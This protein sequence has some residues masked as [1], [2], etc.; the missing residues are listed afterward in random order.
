MKGFLREYWRLLKF[1]KSQRFLLFLAI[2]C[3][4]FSTIFE[5]ISLGLIIPVSD[6]V[7]TNQEIAIPGQLPDFLASIVARLNAIEPLTFLRIIIIFIP[8]LF[9]VKGIFLFL[10]DY[11]MNVVGQKVIF[12]VRNSLFNKFQE[13]SMDFYSRIRMG[14][15]M[16]RVTSDVT[17]IT[18]AISYALKDFLFE[19]MKAFVF[20]LLAF[21]IG[22]KISW[23]LPLVAFVIFPLIMFPVI[24]LG[25]RIK[26]FTT[27]MQEKMADLNALMADAIGGA[28]I[29]KAFSRQSHEMKRFENINHGYYRFNI[30]AVKRVVALS[31]LTEFIGTIGVVFIL[32]VVGR[33]VI[34]GRV[35]FGVFGA[36]IAYLMSTIKPLKKLSGVHATNQKALAASSRIYEIL[37]EVPQIEEKKEAED[38]KGVDSCV[39]FKGVWF[40]YSREDEYVLK[41]INLQ[42]KKGEVVALVG[43]SGAG[44][45]TLVNLIPRFYDAEKGNIT[46]DG[47]DV[48][49]LKIEPLRN[50]VSIVSQQTILFH[51]TIRDNIAYGKEGASEEEIVEA[52]KK[53]HAYEFIQDFP[54]KFDSIVGDRGIKLSGGQMQRISIARAILKNAPILVLDEA[55]SQLDSVSEKFIKEALALLMKGKTTFVIAHRLSTVEKADLIVV[56]EKGRIVETG[57]HSALI[58]G[59]TAYKKLYQLQFNI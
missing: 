45:T 56:L 42:V 28:Y 51:S 12:E 39:E 1:A 58:S 21:Y 34:A 53:A 24:R 52:A 26:K 46:I 18:N 47:R 36:F 37:D 33:E 8:L 31:P 4:A 29:V 22:F 54:G 49:N 38:I 6:R 10:Q 14:E 41:D 27:T 30:K 5:S 15:L 35:S 40:R 59:D 11:L 32:W 19:S 13:L 55:T 7:L 44:K 48:K 16:S 20:L 23:Q 9:L 50:L 43:P 3:M 57:T 25:K 17:I 2:I